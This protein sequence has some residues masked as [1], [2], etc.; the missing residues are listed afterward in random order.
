M[1]CPCYFPLSQPL[2][3]LSSCGLRVA[4]DGLDITLELSHADCQYRTGT[5]FAG[6]TKNCQDILHRDFQPRD[7][8]VNS[9]H[10]RANRRTSSTHR[11]FCARS[12]LSTAYNL[13]A[14]ESRCL[15]KFSDT[16]PLAAIAYVCV[17][18]EVLAVS[19]L[20]LVACFFRDIWALPR[21][22]SGRRPQQLLAPAPQFSSFTSFGLPATSFFF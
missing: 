4:H 9:D 13:R 2:D 10:A 8:I 16:N 14:F 19:R 21:P 3:L 6:R 11:V 17:V 15:Y 22:W 5:R 20:S 12:I 18:C 1:Y 7:L